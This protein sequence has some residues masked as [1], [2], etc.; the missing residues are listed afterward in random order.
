MKVKNVHLALV[1][2]KEGLPQV[3]S[4][5]RERQ[6]AV[7]ERGATECTRVISISG[8]NVYLLFA[9]FAPVLYR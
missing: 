9:L 1:E 5:M 2:K 6:P 7:Q 3:E 4:S 8:L